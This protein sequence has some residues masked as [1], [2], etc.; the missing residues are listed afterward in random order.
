MLDLPDCPFEATRLLPPLDVQAVTNEGI[1][2]LRK[3]PEV[4][5]YSIVG[6]SLYLPNPNDVD[7]C[8]L[9][10]AGRDPCLYA[11]QLAADGWGHCGEYDEQD[12]RWCAIRRGYLNLM[13]TND[14]KWFDGY[15]LAME[16]CEALNLQ[17]KADRIVVCRVVRDGYNA[18]EAKARRDG[19]P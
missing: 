10:R 8:V 15:V 3:M 4:E 1:D 7:F 11:S 16:V 5:K 17:D 19:R 2:E 14:P 12:G 9:L 18:T 13:L 6:S